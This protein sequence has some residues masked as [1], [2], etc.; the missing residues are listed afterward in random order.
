MRSAECAHLYQLRAFAAKICMPTAVG[1][2]EGATPIHL[3]PAGRRRDCWQPQ[4]G[5]IDRH[6]DCSAAAIWDRSWDES[7][8]PLQPRE[9]TVERAEWQMS[10]LACDFEHEAI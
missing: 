3:R 8:G 5:L 2:P 7:H 9:T 10:R 4:R 6:E 1:T